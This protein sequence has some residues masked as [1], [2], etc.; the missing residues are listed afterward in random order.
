MKRAITFSLL[1]CCFISFGAI[2][3]FNLNQV[4]EYEKI[5]GY[6]VKVYNYKGV[7]YGLSTF[8][9]LD[10]STYVHRDGFTVDMDAKGE[11]GSYGVEKRITIPQTDRNSRFIRD[12][13]RYIKQGEWFY[14]NKEGDVDSI[15]Y[16]GDYAGME[17]RVDTTY[18]GKTPYHMYVD[19]LAIVLYD[20]K[21][22][23][24]KKK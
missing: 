16:Y 2:L 7:F 10:D 9:I 5:I 18:T 14:F 4:N 21:R 20:E 3:G 19:S 17:Y 13:I 24:F 22:I 8:S 11:T 23:I 12:G 1:A 6:K 15:V